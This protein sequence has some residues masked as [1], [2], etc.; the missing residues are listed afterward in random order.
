MKKLL[1][2]IAIFI[3]VNISAQTINDEVN[4]I[5]IVKPNDTLIIEK[6]NV[7]TINRYYDALYLV[8]GQKSDQN[9]VFGGIEIKL[10]DFSTQFANIGV[11]FDF[12]Q[13]AVKKDYVKTFHYTSTNCDTITYKINGNTVYRNIYGYTETNCTSSKTLIP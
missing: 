12:I 8:V 6:N 1:L 3:S 10:S 11:M 9:R 5:R 2:L 13:K 4:S 7:I